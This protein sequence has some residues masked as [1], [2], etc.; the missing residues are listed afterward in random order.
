MKPNFLFNCSADYQFFTES[1]YHYTGN[2]RSN[3]V[4]LNKL[5][6]MIFDLYY[7]YICIKIYLYRLDIGSC[8]FENKFIRY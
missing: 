7:M 6:S 2:V 3:I 4:F 1:T 8:K 5:T